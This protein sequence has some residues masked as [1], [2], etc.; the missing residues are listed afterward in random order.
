MD[1]AQNK[2]TAD[3]VA[4]LLA[5][6]LLGGGLALSSEPEWS[7][8]AESNVPDLL[9]YNP[10]IF[11][12]DPA[13][14]ESFQFSTRI[15][16]KGNANY[17]RGT[18]PA[19]LRFRIDLG[20]N[21]SWDD[22]EVIVLAPDL[23]VRAGTTSGGI[24][25][26]R[27]ASANYAGAN[28]YEVCVDSTEAVSES[29]E[30]NNCQTKRFTI[31]AAAEGSGRPD[32]IV[33]SF[34]N[35]RGLVVGQRASGGVSIKNIGSS[36]T[37]RTFRISARVNGGDR[38]NVFISNSVAAS[39]STRKDITLQWT[40]TSAG[41]YPI[42]VCVDSGNTISESDETNNCWRGEW[43]AVVGGPDLVISSLSLIPARPVQGEKAVARVSIQN[44]G[45]AS[46][47]RFVISVGGK[48]E[49]IASLSANRTIRKDVVVPPALTARAGNLEGGLAVCVDVDSGVTETNEENNCRQQEFN[50][51]LASGSPDLTVRSL[52]ITPA[53]PRVGE[54]IVVKAVVRNIGTTFAFDSRLSVRLDGTHQ[55]SKD[56]NRISRNQ[57]AT[58]LLNLPWR[59]EVAGNYTLEA[60]AV[61]GL[62]SGSSSD[63]PVDRVFS[64]NCKTKTITVRAR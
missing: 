12:A 14:G 41:T 21:G 19:R 2:K 59:A 6:T 64:N 37:N 36:A 61:H 57:E 24:G 58:F 18:T 30:T 20:N 55:G 17:V 45:Q 9:P 22:E 33:E 35:A 63:A 10:F 29:N 52:S 31:T 51:K 60:C 53:Q 62:D 48:R 54:P 3:I 8:A 11:P 27:V 16:N 47:G 32:L 38:G 23:V 49:V 42:E 7:L 40:P 13:V 50:V 15:K 4:L 46:A 25:F 1:L 28:A 26:S 34:A 56:G 43:T 5:V 39:G 44:T